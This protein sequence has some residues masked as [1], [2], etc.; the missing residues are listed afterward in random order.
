MFRKR[1]RPTP[2]FQ[3]PPPYNPMRGDHDD[4]QIHGDWPYC[5][6]M[7]VACED[8]YPNYVVCRGFDPRILKFIDYKENSA[9]KPGISVAKPFGCRVTS[10]GAKRY[11]IGEVFPAFLPTQGTADID[12]HYVPPSPVEVKWRL[13][14]NPGVVDGSPYGGPPKCLEDEI[15]ILRDH[16]GKVI[17]WILVH[18]ENKLFRFQSTEDL[19]GSDSCEACVR[20]MSG[21]WP[22]TATIY[23]PNR[24]YDGM[25][26]GTKG[27]VEFQEG[28]YY[29][30][31]AKCDPE[32]IEACECEPSGENDCE[33]SGA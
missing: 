26:A 30:V 12:V 27:Y 10:G 14:Q 3:I 9:E 18:T 31:D 32:E 21:Y 33:C 20:Q 17:N 15:A 7:Q 2:D 25:L 23:D 22:H 4:L 19:I 5:A 29:I 13:G 1:R 11:R 8:K 6:M 28:K 24:V 16:N